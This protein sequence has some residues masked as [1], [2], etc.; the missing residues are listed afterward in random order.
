[1]CEYTWYPPLW[2]PQRLLSCWGELHTEYVWSN[3]SQGIAQVHYARK[4]TKNFS[5][6]VLY[7]LKRQ[8]FVTASP[9]FLWQQKWHEIL[10]SNLNDQFLCLCLSFDGFFFSSTPLAKESLVKLKWR[11]FAR[12]REKYLCVSLFSFFFDS[13]VCMS[14]KNTSIVLF[15]YNF[16][17]WSMKNKG[18]YLN[19]REY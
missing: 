13:Y 19:E 6:L 8:P 1:M 11:G 18:L 12:W 9:S 10:R 14:W 3:C 2:L 17:M 16:E 4:L 15:L 5:V 7:M